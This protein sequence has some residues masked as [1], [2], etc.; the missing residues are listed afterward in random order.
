LP[1]LAR[2]AGAHLFFDLAAAA[3]HP[4]VPLGEIGLAMG[5]ALSRRAGADRARAVADAADEM[6][7]LCGL[8]AWR[9][10]TPAARDAWCC[11]APL[12]ALLDIARWTA[13]E[14]TA[15]VGLARAKAG[16]SERDF[17]ARLIAHPRLMAE[18]TRRFQGA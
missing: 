15:L 14:R 4:L 7:A 16:R 2:I 8:P 3:P 17:V 6:A 13:D 11:L 18:V 9:R 1:R 12:L 10:L 5:A